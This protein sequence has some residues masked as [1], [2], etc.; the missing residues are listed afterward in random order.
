LDRSVSEDE[1][2]ELFEAHGGIV[3]VTIIKDRYTNEPRGFGFVEMSSADEANAA[4]KATNGQMLKGRALTV[5]EAR[6]REPRRDSFGGG[7][8]GG[9]G[10][11][12]RG[13]FGG[14]GRDDH[15]SRGGGYRGSNDRKY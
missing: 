4:I 3:S 8:R 12:S 11:G 13:S 10:G 9:F 15:A 2:K 14:G 1:L 7:S 5:N 6:E